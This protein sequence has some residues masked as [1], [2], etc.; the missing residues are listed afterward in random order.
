MAIRSSYDSKINK[1]VQLKPIVLEIEKAMLHNEVHRF[2]D[3]IIFVSDDFKEVPPFIHPIYS[4][5]KDIAFIDVRGFSSVGQDGNLALKGDIDSELTVLRAK[6][7]LIWQRA[8]RS[9]T[10]TALHFS[11][12]IFVRWLADTIC[13]KQGLQLGHKTKVL[14]VTGLYLIGLYYNNIT[15]DFQI[16]KYAE[17]ISRDF[18]IPLEE[19]FSVIDTLDNPFPRDV[20]E[21][22]EALKQMQ[23]SPRLANLNTVGLYAMLGGS[24]FMTANASQ[25]VGLAVEYPPCFAAMVSMATRHK[26]FK[27]TQI[28]ERV[29]RANKGGAFDQYA[30]SLNA[31]INTNLGHINPNRQRA[32]MESIPYNVMVFDDYDFKEG[33]V[34]LE[35]ISLGQGAAMIVGAGFIAAFIAWLWQ[36]LSGGG[37][38]GGSLSSTVETKKDNIKENLVKTAEAKK[39][40]GKM[41]AEIQSDTRSKSEAMDT[42]L[43]DDA[44][45]IVEKGGDKKLISVVDRSRNYTALPLIS[46]AMKYE[47]TQEPTNHWANMEALVRTIEHIDDPVQLAAIFEVYKRTL[48]DGEHM[49]KNVLTDF[50][51]HPLF[52]KDIYFATL[53]FSGTSLPYMQSEEAMETALSLLEMV[54]AESLDEVSHVA[55]TLHSLSQTAADSSLSDEQL[56]KNTRYQI[57]TV[58]ADVVLKAAGLVR[59]D[60]E[61]DVMVNGVK[62][63]IEKVWVN[64]RVVTRFDW[65][66]GNYTDYFVTSFGNLKDNVAGYEEF[67]KW[68]RSMEMQAKTQNAASRQWVQDVNEAGI[69]DRYPKDLRAKLRDLTQVARFLAF[70]TGKAL[71]LNMEIL[72]TGNGLLE[73]YGLAQAA[74]EKNLKAMQRELDRAGKK[75]GLESYEEVEGEFIPAQ[76]GLGLEMNPW[77]DLTARIGFAI[78]VGMFVEW[79]VRKISGGGSGG[80]GGGSGGGHRASI[81][82]RVETAGEKLVRVGET[83]DK[84]KSDFLAFNTEMNRRKL[85][86]EDL[87]GLVKTDAD[88][89]VLR[90]FLS[91]ISNDDH[92][93]R[94]FAVLIVNG[95]SGKDESQFTFLGVSATDRDWEKW[96]MAALS[97]F[98]RTTMP[99]DMEFEKYLLFC[100]MCIPGTFAI[101]DVI[102]SIDIPKAMDHLE[103]ESEIVEEI[104]KLGDEFTDADAKRIAEEIRK[105]AS[106][107][108]SDSKDVSIP[109]TKGNT[110]AEIFRHASYSRFTIWPAAIFRDGLKGDET[111]AEIKPDQWRTLLDTK[112]LSTKLAADQN[113]LK[114]MEDKAQALQE[115]L[116]RAT[117]KSNLN[118][119]FSSNPADHETITGF[120]GKKSQ[121]MHEI[122]SYLQ[123][124]NAYTR[125]VEHQA[126][127]MSFSC[128]TL[129]ARIGNVKSLLKKV[130]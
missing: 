34:G 67:G 57:E 110:Y 22:V 11:N 51:K 118:S 82:F 129:E 55:S 122:Q 66:D 39:E 81:S 107:P 111:L 61:T 14:A 17:M 64:R 40:I 112:R 102:E 28:G 74:I 75:A 27:K 37:S 50:I 103:V 106:G 121:A 2:S 48:R 105:G 91:A 44:N 43:V 79:L 93:L 13:H 113:T 123:A 19:V 69:W 119:K 49:V 124:V 115:R 80:G 117:R 33:G 77:L 127:N 84:T 98:R 97:N 63:Q 52:K 1:T 23:I 90:K 108:A 32:G 47:P 89:T 128:R 29:D 62:E 125:G 21:Y 114:R 38:G 94:A 104:F 68:L 88:K 100:G 9:E 92:L 101:A 109:G 18:Y 87:M 12:T 10:F 36:K 120:L 26:I 8:P 60:V 85:K 99:N 78:V 71:S 3:E 7:E 46:V 126:G 15:E 54:N 86:D 70:V 53:L 116:A 25:L 20:D 72:N 95:A 56:D 31:L 76:K 35:S 42:T 5:E 96:V 41:A 4:P 45:T 58:H 130:D 30:R 73:A 59:R 24:W 16:S 65:P 83:L 6:L